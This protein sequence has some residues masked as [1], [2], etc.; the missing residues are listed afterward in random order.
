MRNTLTPATI[1]DD[2]FRDLNRVAIGFEPTLR[3]L[4]DVQNTFTSGSNGYPPYDLEMI[5]ENHYRITLAVAGF[6]KDD[7]EIETVD[8]QLV[9]AGDIKTKDEGRQYIFKSIASR[10]FKRVFH[11]AEHVRIDNAA[12]KD[13][14][15]VID[16][17]REVP[18]A[19]KPRKISISVPDL[20]DAELN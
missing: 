6:T 15:L 5:D 10:A 3:K 17:V 12:L 8:N 13:G 9:I 4:H 16:C 14:L 7:L 1:F 19:L 11:L 2:L 18:E 20:I